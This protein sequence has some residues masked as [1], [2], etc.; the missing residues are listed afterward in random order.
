MDKVKVCYVSGFGRSGSTLVGEVL[1]QLEGFCT[2]GEV[3]GF[4][5]RS[6]TPGWHCGCGELVVDCPFWKDVRASGSPPI[7][8]YEPEDY[9]SVWRRSF[10]TRHTARILWDAKVRHRP[11]VPQ[12]QAML[13]TL[14]RAIA[15]AS[16]ASVIVDTSKRPADAI[17][18]SEIDF[19]DLYMLQVVR[20]PRAVAYSWRRKRPSAGGVVGGKDLGNRTPQKSSAEWLANNASFPVLRPFFAKDHY[21]LLRYE[22]FVA[23]PRSTTASIVDFLGEPPRELP[24]LDDHTVLLGPTHTVAGNPDRFRTGPVAIKVDDE[25]RE[26]MTRRDRVV[27]TAVASPLMGLMGYHLRP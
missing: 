24:F 17:I 3:R 12:Y 15:D 4:W 11:V 6:V 19:V 1:G 22:D 8:S 27:A 25:W 13:A 16:G 2:V 5:H 20:D 26:R 10:R 7:S 23:E 18:A 14:Y 9:F 21:K